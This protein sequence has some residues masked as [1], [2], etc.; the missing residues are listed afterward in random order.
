MF[1]YLEQQ[2]VSK[3]SI[4]IINIISNNLRYIRGSKRMRFQ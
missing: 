3:H 2:M 4:I 1:Y